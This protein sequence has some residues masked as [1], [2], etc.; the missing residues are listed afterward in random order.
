MRAVWNVLKSAWFIS[1]IGIILLSA[2]IWF[3]GPIL[4]LG[5]FRPLDGVLTRIIVIVVLFLIWGLVVLIGWLRRRKTNQNL[6]NELA[7]DSA[8]G[9]A[10][11]AADEVARMRERMQDALGVLKQAKLGQGGKGRQYLYQLPWYIMIG[12]PGRVRPRHCSIPASN[13][14]SPIG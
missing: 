11:A 6:V 4:G 13:F 7:Q 1:L 12:P 10:E 3:V 8:G 9:D 5:D 2:L 14:R